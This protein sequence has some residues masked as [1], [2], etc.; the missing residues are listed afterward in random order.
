MSLSGAL[1]YPEGFNKE[2]WLIY[3]FDSD[4]D[5]VDKT[6]RMKIVGGRNFSS[7]FPSDSDAVI[8]NETLMKKLKWTDPV[9]M[10]IRNSRDSGRVYHVI[11]MVQDFHYRSLPEMIGPTMIFYKSDLPAILVVRL[12]AGQTEQT[13]K[14][15]A[16]TWN[17]LNPELPFNYEFMDSSSQELYSSE[18]KLG[19]LTKYLT[20]FAI[21]IASLGLPGLA[22][23]TA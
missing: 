21:F 16:E 9:G 14:R 19:V 17:R 13:I 18:R 2:P 22:S 3:N 20:L 1:Y 6:L 12:K 4:E 5:L 11:G 23:Y 15:I 8:I 10:T 7:S